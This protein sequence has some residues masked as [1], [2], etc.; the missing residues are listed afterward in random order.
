ME[1]FEPTLK[2]HVPLPP[3][4]GKSAEGQQWVVGP[5]GLGGCLWGTASHAAFSQQ[6]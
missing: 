5:M 4:E 6:N 2:P 3:T 1:Q